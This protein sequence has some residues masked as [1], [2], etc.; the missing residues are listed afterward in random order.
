MYQEVVLFVS[1]FFSLDIDIIYNN[2][3]EEAISFYLFSRCRSQ[4]KGNERSGF[5]KVILWMRG[6][7]STPPPEIFP[8]TMN[9]CS[10]EVSNEPT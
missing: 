7:A 4:D 2:P 8:S 6:R 3:V 9:A 10:N 5:L 1:F